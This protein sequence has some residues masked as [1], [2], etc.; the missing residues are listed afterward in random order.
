MGLTRDLLAVWSIGRV[1]P[2]PQRC[3]KPGILGFPF[4][5]SHN[6]RRTAP[7]GGP[8]GIGDWPRIPRARRSRTRTLLF[9][10]G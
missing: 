8:L 9:P 2:D 7:S 4:T 5:L 1:D 10:L 3:S 6:S